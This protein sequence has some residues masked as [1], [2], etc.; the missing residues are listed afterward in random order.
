[1][2]GDDKLDIDTG[3]LAAASGEADQTAAA[4][5]AHTL[6]TPPPSV[7]SLLDGAA[8]SVSAAIQA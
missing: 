6:A 4:S 7:T 3:Q 5:A 1:M 8:V 2:S